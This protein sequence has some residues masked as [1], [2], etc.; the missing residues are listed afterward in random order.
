MVEIK[1]ENYV[2]KRALACITFFFPL[3]C[4][5]LNETF[6]M[7]H[8]FKYKVLLAFTFVEKKMIL[9]AK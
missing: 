7:R 6:R 8:G 1:L 2:P 4:L 5:K 9:K 3:A